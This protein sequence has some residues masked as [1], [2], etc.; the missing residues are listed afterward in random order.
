MTAPVPLADADGSHG[1]KAAALGALIRAGFTV[2]AGVVIA[3][4]RSG[5]GR[6][7]LA[8][9]L[10][11]GLVEVGPGPYAV[12]SSNLLED[13]PEAS[14]AGQFHTTLNVAAGA[15]LIDAVGATAASARAPGPTVYAA[16]LGRPTAPEVPVIVQQMVPADVAGVM[17]TR[18]PVTGAEETMIEATRGLGDSLV[19]G[20]VTPERWTV[21]AAGLPARSGDGTTLLV[22]AQV[23]A[24]VTL[25]QRVEAL[26]G[27]SQDI[28]WAISDGQIWIL[29]SR[30]VT[31]ASKPTIPMTA[32]DVG[33]ARPVAVG[34]PASPG[35]A[36]GTPR[37]I[38]DLDQFGSFQAGEVL[39]CRATSPAWTPLLASASAVVTETGGVLTHAAIVSREFGIPAVVAVTGATSNLEEYAGVIV[40]GD[41]GV[42]AVPAQ[43]TE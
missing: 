7:R 40:D 29:Q 35:R 38:A 17:F 41:T 6:D 19:G 23:T 34:I 31:G 9:V 14:F 25:G 22:P 5:G 24:L 8:D 39:V 26:F 42:V 15:D 27:G 43:E 2:P 36:I 4:Q 16:R 28:E 37:V 21:G 33:S 3:C 20:S 13:G 10:A 1:G 30:P 32:G 11:G 18:H 12:R